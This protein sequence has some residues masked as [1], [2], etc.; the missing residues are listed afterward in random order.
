MSEQVRR[1]G[2]DSLQPLRREEH[3]SAEDAQAAALLAQVHPLA[4]LPDLS[5][6]RIRRRLEKEPHRDAGTRWPRWLTATVA[7]AASLLLL[8][9]AA[10]ATLSA[11]PALRRQVW[12]VV[13]AHLS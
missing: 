13:A 4:P 12:E 9:T 7:I 11:F 5:V 10:A 8:E 3:P 6:A 1:D 2:A